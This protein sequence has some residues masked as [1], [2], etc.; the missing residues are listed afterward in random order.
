MPAKSMGAIASR[1]AIMIASR[2]VAS[3][4]RVDAAHTPS[5]AKVAPKAALSRRMMASANASISSLIAR[6]SSTDPVVLMRH[7]P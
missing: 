7:A 2:P 3:M 4:S 5:S 6:R 1:C